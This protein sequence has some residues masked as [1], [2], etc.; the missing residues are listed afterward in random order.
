MGEDPCSAAQCKTAS[1]VQ[2]IRR[3]GAGG[4]TAATLAALRHRPGTG[5][6][7]RHGVTRGL[8]GGACRSGHDTGYLPLPGRH[9]HL[10]SAVDGRADPDPWRA[11][12]CWPGKVPACSRR[13][14]WR[15]WVATSKE[16]YIAKAIALACD[17][18]R[19]AALRAGLREQVLAS[20]LFDA[21]RFARNFEDA[22]WGM[23]QAHTRRMIHPLHPNFCL[24]RATDS[25][26]MRMNPGMTQQ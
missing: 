20:P 15:E 18:P 8:S 22:L 19:L 5:D 12:V 9:H 17:L 1:T 26:P 6:D 7:A 25:N 21:P 2:A 11:T 10:R 13:R 14:D 3:T 23:W 16:E 24:L 4:T